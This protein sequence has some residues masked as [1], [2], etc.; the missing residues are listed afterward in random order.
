MTRAGQ[1]NRSVT[2]R[3][4]DLDD[5]EERGAAWRNMVTR[6]ARIVAKTGGESVQ[7]QREAGLQPA[8]ITVRRDAVTETIDNGWSAKDARSPFAV[9]DVQSVILTE[10]QDWVEVLAVQRKAGSDG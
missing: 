3:R 8:I 5:N 10:D 7:A 2:F 6:D 1:L 4:R 9:W